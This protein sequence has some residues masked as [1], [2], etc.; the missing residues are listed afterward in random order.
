[1][2]IAHPITFFTNSSSF[3]D[4]SKVLHQS[5][6]SPAVQVVPLIPIDKGLPSSNPRHRSPRSTKDNIMFA[7]KEIS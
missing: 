5:C 3:V 1:M 6:T 4:S 7:I 2:I